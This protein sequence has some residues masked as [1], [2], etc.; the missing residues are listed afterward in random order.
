MQRLQLL[1][2]GLSARD[3]EAILASLQLADGMAWKALR[4]SR[5]MVAAKASRD[6]SL[7]APE[8][9]RVVGVAKL[10]GQVQQMVEESEELKGFSAAAWLG[11]WLVTPLPALGGELPV[12]LLDTM[13]GQG[14]LSKTLSQ[15]QSGAYA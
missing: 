15:M 3:A 11:S 13:E 1:R 7:A 8:A 9:E 10:I 12:H 5:A 4:L 6:E 14:L 2:D